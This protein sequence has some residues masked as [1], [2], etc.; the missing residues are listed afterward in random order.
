LRSKLDRIVD[1][2]GNSL[3]Q[4]IAVTVD[5]GV[6]FGSNGKIN[7]F[8]FRNRRVKVTDLAHEVPERDIPESIHT[9]AVLD[10]GDAQQRCDDRKRLVES[11]ER[12]I[13]PSVQIVDAY[14]SLSGALQRYPYAGKWRAQIVRDIVSYPFQAPNEDL[15][16]IKHAINKARKLVKGI[17][18]SSRR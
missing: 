1:K 17:V 10:L 13:D 9:A 18:C 16:F 14:R 15:D 5:G 6:R 12:L 2:I 11:Y 4:K 3:E 8:V 7:L